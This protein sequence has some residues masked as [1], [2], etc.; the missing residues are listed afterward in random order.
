MPQRDPGRL[1]GTRLPVLLYLLKSVEKRGAGHKSGKDAGNSPGLSDR[2]F[3]GKLD[4]YPKLRSTLVG[5][6]ESY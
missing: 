4:N 2:G 1:Q 5:K 6:E 3:K